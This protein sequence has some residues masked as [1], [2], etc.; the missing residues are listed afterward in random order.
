MLKM[1]YDIYA[2]LPVDARLPGDVNQAS[3]DGFP[4]IMFTTGDKWLRMGQ[5]DISLE[6]GP[7][8]LILAMKMGGG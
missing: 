7:L 1:K 3:L 8:P 2:F 5:N 6:K 4:L